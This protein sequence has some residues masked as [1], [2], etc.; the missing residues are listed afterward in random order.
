MF[1]LKMYA[2]VMG[3]GEENGMACYDIDSIFFLFVFVDAQAMT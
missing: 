1:G 2:L 3:W